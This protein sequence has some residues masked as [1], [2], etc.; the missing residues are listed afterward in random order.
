MTFQV[1]GETAT[2]GRHVDTMRHSVD[3]GWQIWVAK[4]V[5]CGLIVQQCNKPQV[6]CF[7]VNKCKVFFWFALN[8]VDVDWHCL[9]DGSKANLGLN[10]LVLP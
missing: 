9:L 5:V 6:S 1:C 3:V 4:N 10:L 8:I 7:D 2:I